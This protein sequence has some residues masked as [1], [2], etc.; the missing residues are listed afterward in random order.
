[1]KRMLSILLAL[2][3]I[4]LPCALAED[5]ETL[6][7]VVE[8]DAVL[9][10][11]AAA[12]G[13]LTVTG[14]AS[15]SLPADAALITLGVRESAENVQDAQSVVNQKIAAIRAAL[16]DLDIDNK[17]ITTESMYVYANYNYD[18]GVDEIVSYTATNTLCITV[19]NIDIAG[20][21][22][23][24]AFAAG[25]NT[26]ETVDFYAT[27]ESAA[28][29]QAYAEAVAQAM[30]KAQVIADAA[31]MQLGSIED[32]TESGSTYY[33]YDS[34]NKLRAS[35]VA[36]STANGADIQASSVVVTANIT[37]TYALSSN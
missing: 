35:D 10:N 22:I 33:Y 32:I 13:R 9:S 6:P 28:N 19:R 37:I 21:V 29:D 12:P 24:T 15:V 3:L 26:L 31:G 14:T 11:A 30:H 1:M 18:N 36:E 27:D 23:D 25:A 34:G 7:Y 16:V 4:C 17:D 2:M 5:A 8:E 20:T